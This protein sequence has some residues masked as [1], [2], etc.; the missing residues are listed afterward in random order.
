MRS[1]LKSCRWEGKK[2][3]SGAASQMLENANY[4]FH[5]WKLVMCNDCARVPQL[6]C[7]FSKKDTLRGSD[8]AKKCHPVST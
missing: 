5:L 2:K 3:S 7:M 6:V 8:I 4:D 1:Q